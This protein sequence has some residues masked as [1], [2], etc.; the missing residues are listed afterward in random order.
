MELRNWCVNIC[1]QVWIV[2]TG[3]YMCKVVKSCLYVVINRLQ[4]AIG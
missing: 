1:T 4:V 2:Y 3:L